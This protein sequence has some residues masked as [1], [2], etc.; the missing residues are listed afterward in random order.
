MK[1]GKHDDEAD[2]SGRL[3]SIAWAVGVFAA[4]AETLARL[5]LDDDDTVRLALTAFVETRQIKGPGFARR[6]VGGGANDKIINVRIGLIC[7]AH[8][9]TRPL[10]DMAF[11]VP[12]FA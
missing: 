5:I 9:N 2:R 6:D 8:R 10:A 4:V 12:S 3:R 11:S 7:A 1:T